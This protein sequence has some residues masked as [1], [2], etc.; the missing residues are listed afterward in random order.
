ML[1]NALLIFLL[2]AG[3]STNAQVKKVLFLGNS[4]T[5]FNNLTGTLKSL[6]ESLGDSL[7]TEQNT[8]GGFTL[9]GHSTNAA[10]L[11]KIQSQPWDIVVLQ[12]QSQKPSFSPAQV[13]TDV[14][15]YA[16]ILNDSILSN[17]SC[18]RTLFYMTWG[19]ENGDQSNCQ[20][21]PP[22]CTYAGMQGRLRA[23]YMEMAAN[24]YRASVAPVGVAW[25]RTRTLHPTIDLYNPDESHPSP[26]GSYLAACVFYSSIFRESP[27]GSSFYGTLDSATATSL[28]QIAAATVLDADSLSNWGNTFTPTAD[29]S[30]HISGTLAYFTNT[31]YGHGTSIW[32]FGDGNTLIEESPTYG[33]AQSGTYTVKLRVQDSCEWDEITK[34][35]TVIGDTFDTVGIGIV[36]ILKNR[37]NLQ[38]GPNPTTGKIWVKLK[39]NDPIPQNARLQLYDQL[40]RVRRV[41]K[42]PLAIGPNG[43]E[44][45]LEGLQ[46]GVYLLELSVGAYR[47][48]T[49]VILQP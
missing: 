31:S 48:L 30:Q 20:S 25:Q 37:Y 42:T 27:V 47:E 19:R 22:I 39:G 15:P 29:F 1:R 36:D 6:A 23:S 16:T 34:T 43:L 33:Y 28:Q 21:Y 3:V 45:G 38:V 44:V 49:K 32:D 9:E 46:P 41:I 2:F 4:Y 35:I 8:P 13:A 5:N 11:S 17:D 10:S 14:Y 7:Y 40:G 26:E 12:E 24:N 18:T